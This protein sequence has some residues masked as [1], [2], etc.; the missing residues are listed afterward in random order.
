MGYGDKVIGNILGGQRVF[1]GLRPIK[2]FR[3]MR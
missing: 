3:E 1:G 2:P